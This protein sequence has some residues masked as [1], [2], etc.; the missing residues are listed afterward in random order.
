MCAACWR[1]LTFI[2]PPLCG[3]CGFPF[4]IDEGDGALCGACWRDP[5]PFDRARAALVYDAHS[6]QL[7][8]AFKHG[9]RIEAAGAFGRWLARVGVDLL[10]ARAILA[11]VP[12][13][14]WRLWRRRYNQAALLAR[15]AADCAGRPVVADLLQRRRATPSQAGLSPAQRRRNVAGAFRVRR[16]HAGLVR[17][18]HVVLIDDVMTTGATLSSCARALRRAGAERVDAITLARVVRPRI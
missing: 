8:L 18:A 17:G 13:H 4:D 7:P 3:Q 16:R 2:V 10:D 14:R 1:E 12:L 15:A 5:P 9:D 11:P 6:R